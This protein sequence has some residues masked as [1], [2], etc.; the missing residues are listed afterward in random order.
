MVARITGVPAGTLRNLVQNRV[1]SVSAYAYD[2][3][4]QAAARLLEKQLARLKHELDLTRQQGLRPDAPDV[5]E[6]LADIQT[7]TA[8]LGLPPADRSGP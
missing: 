4:N 6:I 7:A 8:A 5:L 2:Q 1:K 3:L